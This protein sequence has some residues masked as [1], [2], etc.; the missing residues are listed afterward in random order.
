VVIIAIDAHIQISDSG[1]IATKKIH[2]SMISTF[3][4]SIHDNRTQ[5]FL[6]RSRPIARIAGILCHGSE[7]EVG[8]QFALVSIDL[9]EK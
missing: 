7:K 3:S 2:P 4:I 5:Q 1:Q 9:R 8:I 6:I